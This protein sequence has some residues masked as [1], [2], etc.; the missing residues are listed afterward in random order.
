MQLG[1][2]RQFTLALV[3]VLV[4]TFATGA[5]IASH[6]VPL[7]ARIA[8]MVVALAAIVTGVIV[9]LRGRLVQPLSGMVEALAERSTRIESATEAVVSDTELLTRVTAAQAASIEQ[10]SATVEELAS[11]TRRNADH[12][13]QTDHLMGETRGAV[14]QATDSMRGLFESIHQIRRSS[15][16]TSRIVKS[17]DGIAFQTN[18][19]ALNAAVEAA[20]AGEHG[21]GFAVVAG[22]VRTLAQRAAD[23]ARDTS[24]L[25]EETSRHVTQAAGLVESTRER[26]D[27]VNEHVSQS[28][29]FVSQI[30]E[31]SAEQARGIDQLNVAFT[32][33]D[34]IVQQ[35]VSSAGHADAA[36]HQMTAASRQ[37]IEIIGGLRAMTEDAARAA[38]AR[39]RAAGALHLRF[40]VT[41]LV[42]ESFTTWTSGIPVSDIVTFNNPHATR[43]TVD[44]VLQLQALVAAGLDFDYE[45]RVSDNNARARHE[46]VQGYADLCAETVWD[47]DIER[48]ALIEVSPL[49]G[50]GEFEKGLY[51]VPGNERVLQVT[52]VDDLR[53]LVGVTVVS[54]KVDVRTLHALGLRGVEQVFKAENLFSAL[55]QRRADFTLLEF[56]ATPDMSVVHDNIKLIPVPGC[57]VSLPGSRSWVVSRRSQYADLL[58]DALER[59]LQALRAEGRVARAFRESGFIHPRV[60]D[61]KRL[62]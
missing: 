33:I 7:P 56:A 34:K 58:A 45:L 31:A 20:R 38:K 39:E 9:L 35:T 12:A 49:I 50:Q 42:A 55:Q 53:P 27:E 14:T 23:A 57:K 1:T 2:L 46:V 36:A 8:E 26:F 21:A 60:V 24:A 22:E 48:D 54:W 61:W 62:N 17:I 32:E 25:I 10:M 4:V 6:S 5:L 29:G 44:F 40:S 37:M 16:D 11:M 41:T 30:A 52:S 19:L 43:G 18:I 13:R 28:G 59:G 15:A 51:T 3:A 47:V